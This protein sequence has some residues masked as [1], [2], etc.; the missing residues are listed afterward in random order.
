[1]RSIETVSP[2]SRLLPNVSLRL[3]AGQGKMAAQCV[4]ALFGVTL[5]GTVGFLLIEQDWDLWDSLYFTLITITTVGYGDEG[6][7]EVGQKFATVLLLV[8]IGTA[9]YSLSVLVQVAVSCQL[10]WKHKMQ[11][12]IDRL[13]DHIVVCGYGRIGRT[14]CERLAASSVAFVVVENDE[15]AYQSAIDHGCPAIFGTAT[16]DEVLHKAGVARARGVVCAVNSDAENVFI[17]LNASELN[18]DAYIVCRAETE[19]TADKVQRAGASLV[20]SPHFSAGVDIATAILRPNLARFLQHG[21]LT[22]RDFEFSEVTIGEGS[23]LAGQTI[24]QF[25]QSADSIVFVAIERPGG[26]RLVRPG[27]DEIFRTG[28]VVIVAGD[29][30]DLSRIY[31]AAQAV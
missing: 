19:G 21:Q 6:L 20:V 25:G 22:D 13:S 17:T 18:K 4:A 2:S 15:Q 3:E 26:K 28:D 5:F 14:I 23:P 8:G 27:G 16:E 24:R 11:Q 29:P 10:A 7:S 31:Q 12:Q 1:M 30:K 9:T